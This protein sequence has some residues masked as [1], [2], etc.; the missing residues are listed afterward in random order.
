MRVSATAEGD[1]L[2]VT[3]LQETRRRETDGVG[4]EGEQKHASR[5]NQ[6]LHDTLYNRPA[7]QRDTAGYK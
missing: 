1:D 6:N 4:K 2:D 5:S 3:R 7:L